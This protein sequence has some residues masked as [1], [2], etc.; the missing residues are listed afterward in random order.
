MLASIPMI[1]L[2]NLALAFVPVVVVL[3]ILFR[4]GDDVV[5]PVYGIVRMIGQ[6][7]VVGYVLAF[8]IEKNEVALVL[9]ALGVMLSAA[10]WIALRPLKADRGRLLLKAFASIAVAGVTTLA[11]V[12]QGVLMLEPWFLPSKM[13][14]L[15]GMIFASAMN[16]VSLVAER[17]YAET[18]NGIG[19]IEARRIALHASLIPNTNTLFAVGIVS[20]PGM[21]TGQILA[22]ANPNDAVRYQIMVMAMVFGTAGIAA[23]CFLQMLKGM[24]MHNDEPAAAADQTAAK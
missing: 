19:Y 18:R 12:T 1:P 10:S 9:A 16:A 21:M 23:A 13:I 17:Y 3:I 22:G 20:I 11:I 8:L 15:A 14:P 2:A 7:L 5:T 24:Q 4:W 6:L